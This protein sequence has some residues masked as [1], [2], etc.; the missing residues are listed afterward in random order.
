M[1]YN[2]RAVILICCPADITALVMT[3]TIRGYSVHTYARIEPTESLKVHVEIAP[4]VQQQAATPR[5][6]RLTSMK[7]RMFFPF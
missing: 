2:C 6:L 3:H 7:P 4:H 5:R 1:E